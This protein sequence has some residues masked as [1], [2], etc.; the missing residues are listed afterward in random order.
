MSF[1]TPT[2]RGDRLQFVSTI[3]ETLSKKA[4]ARNEPVQPECRVRDARHSNIQALQYNGVNTRDGLHS[5]AQPKSS[6][7]ATMLCRYSPIIVL[8]QVSP[9]EPTSTYAG[10][11]WRAKLVR[12][13]RG[14]NPTHRTERRMQTEL[15]GA[16]RTRR[17]GQFLYRGPVPRLHQ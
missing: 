16:E 8:E 11:I 1:D 4:G 15:R 9:H 14:R 2:R 17:T 13:I 6:C 7:G 5:A 12:R 10:D 3:H